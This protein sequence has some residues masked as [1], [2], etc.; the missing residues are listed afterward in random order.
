MEDSSIIELYWQRQERAI[1]ETAQKYGTF[2][3]NLAWNILHSHDDAE[4]CVND[5]YLRAW[6]AIPPTRPSALK[7]WLGRITRN[8][9]L[10]RWRKRAGGH[11]ADILLGELD[12]CIPSP[13]GVEKRW[14]TRRLPAPSPPSCAPFPGRA[15]PSSCCAIGTAKAS[16]LFPIP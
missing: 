6:N 12:D 9:S 2:L 16:F 14:R 13:H 3:R 8:L 4:E 7:V 5:T 1:Q 11:G 10:D 15:G